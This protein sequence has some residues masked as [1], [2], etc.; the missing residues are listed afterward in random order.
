MY[1]MWN[2]GESD[3]GMCLWIFWGLEEVKDVMVVM[4]F[5]VSYDEFKNVSIGLFSICMGVLVMIY[6][7]GMEGGL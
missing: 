5:I 7:Y 4:S 1:D 3:C 2:Y 6:V